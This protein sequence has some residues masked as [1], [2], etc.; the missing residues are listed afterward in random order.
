MKLLHFAALVASFIL[1]LAPASGQTVFQDGFEGVAVP[2]WTY[3]S[4]ADG[5]ALVVST[6]TPASGTKH[7]VLDDAVSD[8]TFSASEATLTLD[9]R[10]KKNVVLTFKVKSLGNEPHPPPSSTYTG[11]N[12]DAVAVSG[13]GGSSWRSAQSLSAVTTDWQ[14]FVLNLDSA[15]ALS[16]GYGADFKIRFSQYDNAAAP[17]DGIALDDVLVQAEDDQRVLLELP[18]YAMEGS[19]P[20]TAYLLLAIA[21]TAATTVNLDISPAGALVFPPT[22]PVAAGET[23]IMVDFTVPDDALINLSRT[24]VVTPT[25][26]G[27]TGE[28]SA[29]VVRDN[30]PPPTVTLTVPA[31]L[32]EGVTSTNNATIALS[33]AATVDISFILNTNPASQLTLPSSVTI[34]A[35]QLQ[36]AFTVNATNDTALDGN[37]PVSVSATNLALTGVSATTV[38]IDNELPALGFTVPASVVEGTVM[39]GTVTFSGT[40][41]TDVTVTLTS[42]NSATLSVPASVVMPAGQTSVIFEFTAVNDS[43]VNLSRSV[44][45]TGSGTGVTT[46][47]RSIT[48]TDDEPA[49]VITLTVPATLVEGETP[50]S[51]ASIT[52]TP[53]ASVAVTINLSAVPSAELTI[54]AT[55][56]VPASVASAAFTARAVND[57]K[58]DGNLPVT[59]TAF[60]T[61]L[62]TVTTATTAVDNETRTLTV[63]LATTMSE[64]GTLNGTV[65]ISGTLT[66]D[67]AVNLAGSNS[68]ALTVPSSAVITAGT[69]SATFTIA[70]P[71]NGARDGTRNV[72]ITAEA[73][74]FT[75]VSR[76][77]AVK[78][79][80]PAAYSFTALTDI[81]NISAVVPVTVSALDIEN[82]PIT[83]YA[84]NVNLSLMNPDGS[85]STVTPA[86]VALSGSGWTGNLTLPSAASG[87]LKLRAADAAGYSGESAQFDPMRILAV[88]AADLAWDSTRGRLY[89]SVP[90]TP[91]GTHANKI[92]AIDPVTMGIPVSYLSNQDPTKLAMTSGN[93]YLYAAQRGNGTVVRVDPSTMNAISTFAVGVHASYGTLYAEDISTVA[94][95][96]NLVVVSQFRASVS[97]RHNGVAVY[98][99]G[100][101]RPDK[102]QDHTGSNIIEPSA[103]P[104]L[105][106]GYN[107]ESTEYGFRQLRLTA[108][109]MTQTTVS[110]GLFSGFSIEMKSAGNNVFSTNGVEVD[111]LGMRRVGSFYTNGTGAVCP[112]G[113]IGRV[114]YVEPVVTNGAALRIASFDISTLAR[115]RS[116]TLPTIVNSAPASFV[117]WGTSGLAFRYGSNIA[118]IDSKRLVPSAPPADLGVSVAATPNPA[119]VG[120]NLAYTVTVTNSG[121]NNAPN[122]QV[123]AVLSTSQTYVS[124]SASIGAVSVAGSVVTLTIPDLPSGGSATFTINATPQSA[125][126][127]SCIASV[128]SE[129]LD[130]AFPNNT[131][132]KVVSV[133]FTPAADS[134][135]ALRINANNLIYDPTRGLLW[136]AISST[137]EAPLGRS[138]VSI[139]PSTG[140]VSDP[141]PLNAD[142]YPNSIALSGNGR[143]LY[144]GLSDSPEVARVD[145]SAA[146]PTVARIP[147]GLSQ[148]GDLNYAQDIE[149]LDGAGTSFMMAGAGDHSAAIYDGTVMRT[150]RSGIYTVDRIERTATPGVFIG[151]N[152]YTSGF[153]LTRL[154][155]AP[156]GVTILQ[157]IGSLVSG[158]YV[159]I[160]AGGNVILSATGKLVNNTNLALTA[161]LTAGTP[162]LDVANQRAFLLTNSTLNSH[163][164]SDGATQGTFTLTGT[165]TG[166]WAQSLT[167]WGLDGFAA[168]G[169]DGKLYIARWSGTIPPTTDSDNDAIGDA[170]EST[171][172]ASLAMSPSGDLDGDGVLNALE[173][174]FVS[175]PNQ[176]NTSPFTTTVLGS[177]SNRALQVDFPRRAGIPTSA[178]RYEVSCD[179]LVWTP[180]T[181]HTESVIQTQT[182]NGVTIQ[183][184]RVTFPFPES[185]CG[186]FRIAW[187]NP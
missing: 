34:P 187:L 160:K 81:V 43:L 143:Y 162:C 66:T 123:N 7:L 41:A 67:L 68:A 56:T 13:N 165:P 44:T 37:V 102:T 45:I 184:V 185:D 23:F 10:N 62:A 171:Y 25:M 40:R 94:G 148:W 82:T 101:I 92:I 48:V 117:R 131:A 89:A 135:N 11:R 19:G 72:T 150:N 93:E 59:I 155:A 149:V 36:A 153:G 114:F 60:A 103:D 151:Y 178:Y 172:F 54:P 98:D 27:A 38:A 146:P 50:S 95:Q 55:V 132:S 136:T 144:V 168:T 86:T 180:A 161:T 97:P 99:N 47:T 169:S 100:V 107:T 24:V 42:S 26:A 83:G 173:W 129:A 12:Y 88:T 58:I 64:S 17:V 134:V 79:N 159:D 84:G 106:F 96:P 121:P 115:I 74:T 126:T 130:P 33:S 183:T 29:L 157:E 85:T 87:P 52:L 57:T 28:A 167:R 39:Q 142:P 137:V 53:P 80:D 166:S 61:G 77:I 145:L 108:T 20:H 163:R 128:T 46:G 156:S 30:E 90:A 105:F 63:N 186:L 6:F 120:A 125:G 179:L 3:S 32:T 51:N 1:T 2:Q 124:A 73:A 118:V 147:L 158:Y 109:G 182:I 116:L 164:F 176:S 15:A 31:T 5:R 113:N 18:G 104:T 91:A 76:V 70:A 110:S 141:I 138:I 112:D 65:T 177:G 111:G 152:N 8:T 22:V 49:P 16:G 174:F 170:W 133:G 119:Q 14:T 122:T 140:L 154:S 181:G 71:D 139:N 175:A 127:L 35:G 4:T 21:P 69:T 9:L 78:D 75:G